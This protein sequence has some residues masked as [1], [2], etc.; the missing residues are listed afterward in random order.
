MTDDEIPFRASLRPYFSPPPYETPDDLWRLAPMISTHPRAPLF[1]SPDAPQILSQLMDEFSSGRWPA[2][3]KF[4]E[5]L[6]QTATVSLWVFLKVIAAYSGAYSK[7]NAQL[8]LEMC[9]FRQVCLELGG[10]Y[11]MLTPRGSFKST[12]ADHGSIPWEFIRNPDE[13]IGIFAAII[14][15]SQEFYMQ[16]KSIMD[17][18]ELFKTLWPELVPESTGRGSLWTDSSLVIPARRKR[19]ATPSLAAYTASGSVSGTHIGLGIFDDI[20]TDAMLNSQRVATSEMIEKTNWFRTNSVSLREDVF[21]SRTIDIGTRYST[22]DPHEITQADACELFGDWS[23][24]ANRYQ[25]KP[26]GRWRTYYRSAKVT[27][28]TVEESIQPK[29]YPIEFLN[30][31]MAEDPWTYHYQ[32][33]NNA[34]GL[35]G[36][37]LASY[38]PPECVFTDE[39]IAI[40]N[41]DEFVRYG[42]CDITI[43]LD[44][45]G[46]STRS[47]V[48]TSQTAMAIVA[49]D[50]HGRKFITGRKGYVKTTQ[51]LDWVFGEAEFYGEALA[52]TVIEE[53]AG[54]AAL[55]SII[56]REQY[57]RNIRLKY[58]PTP[59][60]GD[61]ILTIKTIL[62]PELDH[63]MIYVDKRLLPQFMDELKA[64]PNGYAMDLLDAVKIAIKMSRNPEGV[65]FEAETDLQRNLNPHT[66]Y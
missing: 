27:L 11:A 57:I 59:A 24:V 62:Q 21:T 14:D 35:S 7:L 16:A 3:E 2:N 51:W 8:H 41:T 4:L 22:D 61:K 47:S 48:R 45:A 29:A 36:S 12:I 5:L 49:R 46:R 32:Y 66:G 44:P 58:R 6:R 30:K 40:P 53:A 31:L 13:T 42:E 38:A 50:V 63:G 1:N 9:N 18:N 33:E 39:G 43:A 37:E 54:F 10:Y 26:D 65:A 23:K 17:S 25:R 20:V 64:F 28:G 19:K 60:L 15:K 34:V 56:I 52:R 55:D